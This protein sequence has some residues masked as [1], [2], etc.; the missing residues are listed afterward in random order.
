MS[1]SY[2]DKPVVNEREYPNIVEV[3][4]GSGPLHVELNRR[5]MLF[6]KLRGIG[7]RHGRIINRNDHAYYHWC[8]PDLAA[9]SESPNSSVEKFYSIERSC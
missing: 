3:A 9:A 4:V 6:H 8:F 5:M 2:T 7:P 1:Q